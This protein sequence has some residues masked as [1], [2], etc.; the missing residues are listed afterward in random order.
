M[1]NFLRTYYGYF[2]ALTSF[3][4][5]FFI[6]KNLFDRCNERVLLKSK[7]SK[8]KKYVIKSKIVLSLLYF[9]LTISIYFLCSLRVLAT[10]ILIISFILLLLVDKFSTE[11]LDC[12]NVFDKN[13]SLRIVWKVFY[14]V[15]N[16]IFMLLHPMHKQIERRIGKNYGKYKNKFNEILFNENS[17]IDQN[18]SNLFKN[19]NLFKKSEQSEMSDYIL[20]KTKENTKINLE[21]ININ[22]LEN[23]QQFND[24]KIMKYK[25]IK[26]NNV[27]E[28]NI[29]KVNEI[30]EVNVN[31]VNVNETNEVNVNEVN[32]NELNVNEQNINES[33][34]DEEKTI[35]DNDSN[36]SNDSKD[37]NDSNDDN[38]NDDNNSNN[39][40]D[41]NDNV[42]EE[43]DN[44][45]N[46]D[47]IEENSEEI[48]KLLKKMNKAFD[49]SDSVDN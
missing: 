14:T 34:I 5:F 36:Y 44:N 28:V 35:E 7:E 3:I 2:K 45:S 11:T 15:M 49:T 42:E 17:S 46:E 30:N 27:N 12:F 16:I 40:N 18:F 20:N 43:K 33:K 41:N 19:I 29:N 6:Y 13:K 47:N 8:K 10:F 9:V 48:M 4:L 25:K 23:E 24:V 1:F 26:K 32:V 38:N 22:T 37:S 39:N 31:E 21:K